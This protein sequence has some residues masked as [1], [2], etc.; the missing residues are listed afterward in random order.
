MRRLLFG[1]IA[2][3]LITT[4][5]WY[6]VLHNK[7][8]KNQAVERGKSIYGIGIYLLCIIKHINVMC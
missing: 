3:I 5:F 2:I 7:S 8:Y 4:L 6:R 1:G